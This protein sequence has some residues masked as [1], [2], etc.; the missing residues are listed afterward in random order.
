MKNLKLLIIAG[1]IIIN[2][3]HASHYNVR[4]A[5]A[6]RYAIYQ[7]TASEECHQVAAYFDAC[8]DRQTENDNYHRAWLAAKYKLNSEECNRMNEMSLHANAIHNTISEDNS[9][10]EPSAVIIQADKYREI[11][12]IQEQKRVLSGFIFKPNSTFCEEI[13][14][15]ERALIESIKQAQRFDDIKLARLPLPKP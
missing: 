10:S 4:K 8:R 14:P 9:Y 5:T 3:I 1:F 11:S 13:D 15:A 12:L 7:K 2:S 6:C